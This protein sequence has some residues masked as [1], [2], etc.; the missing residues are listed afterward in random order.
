MCVESLISANAEVVDLTGEISRL[1]VEE[2]TS[3][4][5]GALSEQLEKVGWD[6]CYCRFLLLIR[7]LSLQIVSVRLCNMLPLLT[8]FLIFKQNRE[9]S[10]LPLLSFFSYSAL[11]LQQNLA[12]EKPTPRLVKHVGLTSVTTK[13]ASIKSKYVPPPPQPDAAADDA[14]KKKRVINWS[15]AD[16][17]DWLYSIRVREFYRYVIKQRFHLILHSITIALASNIR[18]SEFSLTFT[19]LRKNAATEGA[20]YR[21]T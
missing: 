17:V 5:V 12:N 19:A 15:C 18:W 7:K 10:D 11:S 21:I 9:C 14:W 3:Y 13:V 1:S 20:S 4:T 2:R 8:L 16:V 6:N